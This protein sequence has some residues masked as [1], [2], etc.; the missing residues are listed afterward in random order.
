MDLPQAVAGAIEPQ[1]VI[2][3]KT[4]ACLGL[5]IGNDVFFR[6][7][8]VLGPELLGTDQQTQIPGAFRG[9]KNRPM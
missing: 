4:A 5:P 7:R 6:V 8:Q 9:R 1:L 2:F 3:G